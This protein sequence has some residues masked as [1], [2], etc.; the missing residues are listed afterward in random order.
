MVV[1]LDLNAEQMARLERVCR[2]TGVDAS[3]AVSHALTHYEE[4]L[5]EDH[6]THF[7]SGQITAIEAGL[8]DVSHGRLID[9][10]ELMARI[11]AKHGW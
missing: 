3:V 1:T 5:E 2:N 8:D 4:T 11:N 7:T 6:R 10:D 9:H